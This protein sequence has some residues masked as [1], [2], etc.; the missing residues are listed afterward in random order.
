MSPPAQMFPRVKLDRTS[1]AK[2]F[3][4]ANGERIIKD[5]GEKTLPFKSSKEV[6]RCRK[7]RSAN[8]VKPLISMRHV[9]Q[10]GNV[11][12]LDVKNPH[13]RNNRDG[14][15]IK[16]D[17]NNEVCTMDMWACLDETGPVFSW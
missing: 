12:V 10:A 13:K 7:F 9:V 6:H 5:L 4:A 16:L 2:K 3:V 11:V 15:V 17:V 1:T 14:T 8:V